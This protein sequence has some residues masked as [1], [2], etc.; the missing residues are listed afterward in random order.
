MRCLGD[1]TDSMDM[2]LG[3]SGEVRDLET[4]HEQSVGPQSVRHDLATER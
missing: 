3:N 1:I 2:N 4:S